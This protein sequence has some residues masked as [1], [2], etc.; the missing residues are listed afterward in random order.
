MEKR[1]IIFLVLALV[2]Q[3]PLPHVLY[4]LLAGAIVVLAHRSNIAR[5]LAG[6]ER[7][8]SY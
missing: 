7:R 8:Q 2:A 1:L 5:L 4:G 6:T 3:R